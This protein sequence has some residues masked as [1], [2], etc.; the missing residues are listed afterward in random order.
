MDW[1][2]E[3]PHGKAE[4]VVAGIRDVILER[5]VELA[6]QLQCGDCGCHGL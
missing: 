4:D 6:K 2:L 3:D 1:A 5:V